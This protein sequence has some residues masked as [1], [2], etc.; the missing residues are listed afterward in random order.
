[1]R[2]RSSESGDLA[3]IVHEEIDRLPERYRLPLLLC[4][5]ESHTQQEAACR[6]GWPLGTVKSRQARPGA[7]AGQADA[8]GSVGSRTGG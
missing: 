2:D 4:D 7:A 5:L 1:M 3:S 6:L 8:P